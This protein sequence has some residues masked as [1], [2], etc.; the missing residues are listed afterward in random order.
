MK[1]KI[2]PKT[3]QLFPNVIFSL[4]IAIIIYMLTPMMKIY[5]LD[6]AEE[7]SVYE[8]NSSIDMLCNFFMCA[9]I[10]GILSCLYH[11][12]II[13][14]KF[15][16]ACNMAGGYIIAEAAVFVLMWIGNFKGIPAG[17]AAVVIAARLFPTLFIILMITSVLRGAA[18]FYR[19]DEKKKAEASCK[20][21]IVY[22][23]A[24]FI[25]QMLLSILLTIEEDPLRASIVFQV[26]V[27][28]VYIYN[29]VIML[30][31]YKRIKTFCYNYYLYSH[32][33]GLV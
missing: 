15:G 8:I 32:N 13:S 25:I 16:A 27:I 10:V 7:A 9:S 29:I 26:I 19:E 20:K 5:L 21:A 6:F 12:A 1:E 18:E 17:F 4:F 14:K 2:D 31:T 22:W 11:M 33:S 28:A 24:A 23:I 30:L 3:L